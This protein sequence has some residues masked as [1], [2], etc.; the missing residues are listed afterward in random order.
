MKQRK[1]RVC[2]LLC[3]GLLLF[4]QAASAQFRH[5]WQADVTVGMAAPAQDEY[6]LREGYP[7]VSMVGNVG[8]GLRA[9]A[10]LLRNLHNRAAMGVGADFSQFSSLHIP[11]G[12]K[13]KDFSISSKT[14][15]LS[16]RAYPLG[17][18]HR[19]TPYLQATFSYGQVSVEQGQ[20]VYTVDSLSQHSGNSDHPVLLKVVFTKPEASQRSAVLGY[21]GTA[22]AE[23]LLNDVVGFNWQAGYHVHKTEQLELLQEDLAYW[24]FKAGLFFRMF[25][26]KRFY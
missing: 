20:Y 24:D 25:K 26:T 17:R 7:H 13:R 3:L 21:G 1:H 22:G 18:N 16:G 4:S 11:N 6:Y 8:L 12:E 5:K 19:I 15:N 10:Q 2:F 14:L 9:Q 23:M